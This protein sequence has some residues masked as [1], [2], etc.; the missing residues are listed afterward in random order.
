MALSRRVKMI[1]PVHFPVI[2]AVLGLLAVAPPVSAAPLTLAD[3][4][5]KALRFAPS[6]AMAVA[7]SDLSVARSREMRAP[8]MPSVSAGT[9]YYQAPGY[10]QTITNRGL[11]SAMLTLNWTA[12]DFGRR[13]ARLR[14]ARY[15]DEAAKLGVAAVRAQTAFDARTAYF[16]LL[17]AR[18]AVAELQSNLARLNR[19]ISTVEMLER[20]GRAVAND[21]LKVRSARDGAELSLAEAQSRKRR[22]AL[23]LGSLIG[24][25]GR[26]DFEVSDPGAI[27]PMPTGDLALTP[28]LR[29][30]QR[31][32]SAAT[33]QIKAA[34]A[35]RYPTFV[36]A[37]TAGYLGI[38]P[39]STIDHHLGGSYDGVISVPIFQGGLIASHIDQAR[40]RREQARAQAREAAYLLRRR[41]DDAADRHRKAREALTILGR[42]QPTA[43]DAFALYWTRFLGGGNVT[44]L[45][46]LTA[47]EQAESLRLSRFDQE[48][49]AREAAA[50]GALL[51]GRTE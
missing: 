6:V 35:E 50:E 34:K 5:G 49:A 3:A 36:L 22:A 47:Y 42:A 18:R 31:A 19:Y 33:M 45:E 32:V 13:L 14:S 38:D 21:V 28:V 20:S 25:F 30:A 29:A 2:V 51:L 7:T 17:R 15:A 39:P 27:E 43:D 4:V 24:D 48:F 8:L 40:A 37:L 12:F 9:E 16:G 41:L 44:L 26:S 23:V 46:V 11:S 1:A 10:D